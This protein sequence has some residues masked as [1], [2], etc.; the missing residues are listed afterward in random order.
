MG[1]T[2]H[3][4]ENFR[5]TTRKARGKRGPQMTIKCKDC[6]ASL[7]LDLPFAKENEQQGDAALIEIGGVIGTRGDW[8]AALLPILGRYSPLATDLTAREVNAQRTEAD[9][10]FH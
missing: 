1:S 10:D 9:R 3:K 5:V 2:K 8:K 4:Y 6:Q 7:T